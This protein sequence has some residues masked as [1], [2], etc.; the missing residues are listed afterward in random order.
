MNWRN[1]PV[2]EHLRRLIVAQGPVSLASY[3]HL[4]LSY[5]SHGYYMRQDPIGAGGGFITA[6]EISQ[7]FGEL[8]GLWCVQCWNDMGKPAPFALVELGPGRGTLMVD[9]LRA[10]KVMPDFLMAAQV[11]LVETSPSLQ[12]KQQAALGDLPCWHQSVDSLP[13]LPTL[14]IANE[15]FD[16]LPIRQ[17][18]C[19][20]KAWRERMISINSVTDEF[21]FCL[22]PEPLLDVSVL[23]QELRGGQQGAI[24]EISPTGQAILSGLAQRIMQ[25]GGAALIIDYG[26]FP[27][28]AGDTL[29]A[30]R[31]HGMCDPLA[32]PGSADITAHVDFAQLA[33]TAIQAGARVHGPVPQEA[34]LAQLGITARAERLSREADADLRTQIAADVARLTSPDAMGS[35]FK[36]MAINHP[37]MSTPAGFES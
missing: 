27:S 11:H 12:A 32:D 28:A 4:A 5:P 23:P 22:A 6:P 14:I 3:M 17:F 33:Q 7:I 37:A 10:A 35:L 18:Q 13:E 30:V 21:C 9:A 34:F 25:Y 15:F 8:I 20:G 26:Y 36:V 29:Q 1:N 24:A 31:A 19:M 16:A 2:S